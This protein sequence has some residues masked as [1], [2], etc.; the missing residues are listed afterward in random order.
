MVR[1]AVIRRLGVTAGA[2]LLLAACGTNTPAGGDP[3]NRRLHQLAADAIFRSVAPEARHRALRLTAASYRQPGFDGGGWSGPGVALTFS[4]TTT[5]R[6]VY[7]FYARR[8]RVDGWHA[9]GSGS[10]HMTDTW[11]RV[12]RN[13][14]RATLS[15]FTPRPFAPVSGARLYRLNGGI[16]LPSAGSP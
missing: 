6:G 2:A 8:A 3:G 15:L 14:A 9:V 4:S 1:V 16:S 10:L 5:A 13:G 7:A 12:Y 11:R